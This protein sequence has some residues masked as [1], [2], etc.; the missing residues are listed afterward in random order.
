GED[1]ETKIVEFPKLLFI[2][3]EGENS[4]RV[5]DLDYFIN[6]GTY[7][8]PVLESVEGLSIYNMDRE[9]TIVSWEEGILT[10]TDNGLGSDMIVDIDELVIGNPTEEVVDDYIYVK[11]L[12]N[13]SKRLN[14]TVVEDFRRFEFGMFVYDDANEN[15]SNYYMSKLRDEFDEDFKIEGESRKYAYIYSPLKFEV[16]EDGKSN[17]AIYGSVMIKT[18]K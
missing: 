18:Y 15:K 10:L 17:R 13:M 4:I 14:K 7:K 3:Y 1:I 8:Q 11:S 9:S 5:A 12:H 2:G 6:Y 16:E